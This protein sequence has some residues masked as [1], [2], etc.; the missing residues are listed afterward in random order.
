[1]QIGNVLPSLATPQKSSSRGTAFHLQHPSTNTMFPIGSLRSRSSMIPP[2]VDEKENREPFAHIL[3]EHAAR[4]PP[5]G[6]HDLLSSK[7]DKGAL[8][9]EQHSSLFCNVNSQPNETAS[10]PA[11]LGLHLSW[12]IFFQAKQSV[13]RKHA[14]RYKATNN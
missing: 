8:A 6:K 12:S 10:A 4:W 1:M 11:N 14:A 7:L 2:P 9:A 13:W 5:I 3:H